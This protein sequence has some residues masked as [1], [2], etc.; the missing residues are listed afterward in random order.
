MYC[1]A[2]S[3]TL[4]LC[5]VACGRFIGYVEP[6]L[7]VWDSLAGIAIV[8]AAGGRVNGFLAG[9]GLW[10]GNRVVACLP[11]STRRSTR[12][13]TAKGHS[14]AA[15]RSGGAAIESASAD[16]VENPLL[17]RPDLARPAD[18]QVSRHDPVAT[19]ALVAVDA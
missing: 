3:G 13:S 15:P 1:R 2:G 5:Y 17:A 18:D 9:D 10:M 14:E 6:H 11:V 7:N 8:E 19:R 4:G 16:R 12:C